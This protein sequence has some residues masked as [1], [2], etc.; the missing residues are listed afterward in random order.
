MENGEKDEESIDNKSNDVWKGRER[1]GH[2][3]TIF[4]FSIFKN[5]VV[6]ASIDFF[7]TATKFRFKVS[8]VW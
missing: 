3:E 8:I 6:F 2:D 1:E 7:H 5:S 4:K